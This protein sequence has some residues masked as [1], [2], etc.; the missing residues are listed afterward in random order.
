MDDLCFLMMDSYAAMKMR[1]WK[2]KAMYA[3]PIIKVMQGKEYV[4]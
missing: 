4:C 1:T 2:A 3:K